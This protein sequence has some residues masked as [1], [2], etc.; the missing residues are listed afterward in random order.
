VTWRRRQH[1]DHGGSRLNLV[2]TL[3]ILGATIFV[4]V[5]ILPPYFANYQFEDAV[6]SEARFALSGY[7]RKTEDD[8]RNDVWKKAQELGIPLAKREAIQIVL[9]QGNVTIS[10][11]YT[12]PVDLLVYQFDLQFHPHANNYTI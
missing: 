4:G 6:K 7:P 3:A 5:K 11:D 10:T 1:E 12:V 8:I 2:L 9:N